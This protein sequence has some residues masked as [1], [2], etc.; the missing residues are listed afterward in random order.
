[1]T[2]WKNGKIKRLING[3]K[4]ERLKPECIDVR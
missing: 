3:R 2:G 1:M 4:K